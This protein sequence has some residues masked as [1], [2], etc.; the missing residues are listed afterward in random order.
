MRVNRALLACSLAVAALVAWVSFAWSGQPG[1]S[2]PRTGYDQWSAYGGG[3]RQIR[4][5][6][7]DQ[8]NRRNL[9][10]LQIAWTYD[11]GDAFPGSEMQCNPLVVGALLYATSPRGRVFALHAATGRGIWSFRPALPGE[12]SHGGVRNRGLMYWSRDGQARIYFSYRHLLYALDAATGRLCLDFGSRGAID[13]R[14]HLGRPPDSV[15]VSLNTPGVV[16][17]D[18]LILGSTVG[19]SL[20]SAPGDIRAYDARSGKLRWSFRTIPRPGEPGHDTWPAQAWKTAGGANSWA[21]MSLDE[22]RGLVY[23]PTGSA[24]FDFFGGNRPGHNLFANS[25][26]CLKAETGERVWHFQAVRHDVWDRDL[27]APPSLVTVF[28]EGRP[29]EAVAQITKSGHVFTFDRETGRPL[30]PLRE[31]RVPASGVPGERLAATQVLPLKPPPFA[32]QRLTEDLLTDRT[33]EAH[34]EVLKRFRKL[35]NGPQFTPPSKEGTLIFPG[36]DGGGQWGGAAFDPESG[37]LF[38]NSSEMA[39]V[40]R[41]VEK[42]AAEGPVTA[43]RLYQ[44][45]CSGCHRQDRTGTPP[46]FPS[47]VD[48]EQ[49]RPEGMVR[50]TLRQ[51]RGR[52]PGFAHLGDRALEAI[53]GFVLYGRDTPVP[54]SQAGAPLYHLPYGHDG[55]NRFLDPEGYPAVKPPWG[56]LNAIDL[57]KGEIVW[58]VPLGEIPELAAKGMER[59]GSEN[60][61]GPI[62]TAGGLVFIGAGN[63][64]RKFRAFDKTNGRLLWEALLPA[65]GNATPAT[66]EVAGRQYVVI[67]AGGGKSGAPSGGSYVA[68]ALPETIEGYPQRPKKEIHEG[69]RRTTKG[70]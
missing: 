32:R 41:L 26:L 63:F 39:W 23:V 20:P 16:Y 37:R 49:R 53:L 8:I 50:R 70:H 36:F 48:L 9:H 33:P 27:P 43:Q 65:S 54:A 46:E 15:T 67:A 62:V 59:T 52:M 69:P 31:F 19:E 25:L 61:G 44:W 12:P 13:L 14:R 58:Q 6:R 47:L 56:T 35:R 1:R 22:Q 7:L 30:F 68:F 10:R 66:Y 5:S 64:D 17:R 2:L 28:R 42:K 40:L 11:T 21:G 29:V 45:N 24:A 34:R 4:Y 51:G 55:Y 57:D 18:L 60:Y 38:V 3:N